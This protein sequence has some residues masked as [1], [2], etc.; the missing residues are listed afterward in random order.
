MPENQNLLDVENEE[1]TPQPQALVQN[2]APQDGGLITIP[3]NRS[4]NVESKSKFIQKKR[5]VTIF[6]NKK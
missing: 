2:C 1:E 5:R 3:Q 6:T 4:G